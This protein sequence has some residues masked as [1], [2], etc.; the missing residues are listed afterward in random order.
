[1][2]NVYHFNG[3]WFQ[4]FEDQ[5]I[6][7]ILFKLNLSVICVRSH[8]FASSVNIRS[9]CEVTTTTTKNTHISLLLHNRSFNI[10]PNLSLSISLPGI[11]HRIYIKEKTQNHFKKI[12]E[13][14]HGQ[15]FVVKRTF[16]NHIFKS[17]YCEICLFSTETFY[18]FPNTYCLFSF[19]VCVF[20][21]IWFFGDQCRN[22]THGGK[23]LRIQLFSFRCL[24]L[25]SVQVFLFKSEKNEKTNS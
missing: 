18:R 5:S 23:C 3:F 20:V 6:T 14:W 17:K 1:M 2:R 15:R 21:C 11:N 25:C 12:E 16:V 19:G 8:L 4:E 22:Q 10:N 24:S 13:T 7:W 9:A